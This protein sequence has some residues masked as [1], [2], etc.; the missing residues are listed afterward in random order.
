M[1]ND[2][3][4]GGCLCGA[5]RYGVVGPLRNVIYCHCVQ[6]RRTSGHFVAATSCARDDLV[7]QEERGLSWYASSDTAKRGFCDQCGSSLFWDAA[8]RDAMG[9]MAGTL[10]TPTHITATH[11]IFVE[12]A[13]DYY[14]LNDGLPQS[15]QYDDKDEGDQSGRA[16]D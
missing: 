10:D 3:H 9:I 4:R 16:D 12:D 2:I 7:M 13:S 1:T 8:H 15:L 11:H 6:C 5:V 14:D